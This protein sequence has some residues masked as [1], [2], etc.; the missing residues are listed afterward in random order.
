MKLI[1]AHI[2]FLA[3][4][5]SQERMS[6]HGKI[7]SSEDESAIAGASVLIVSTT[8]G[9]SSDAEGRFSLRKIPL[10]RRQLQISAV[11]YKTQVVE[12]GVGDVQELVIQLHPSLIQTQGVVV[13]A[14]K[15]AQSLEEIPVSMSVLDAKSFEVRNI[16]SL[17]DALRY[18]P[19]VNFQQSQ[20]NIR[21]SSG[22]SR[23]V[24]SR[25]A[26]LMDGVPLLAGDTKE[27]TFESIPVFQIDRVE[28]LKGAGSTL[29]GSGALGGVVN[30][31]TKDAE[32]TPT[33][34]WRVYSGMY[35]KPSFDQWKWTDAYR[36][37]NGQFLGF[38]SRFE[39]LGV[40]F[41][42]NRLSDDGYRDGDWLRRYNGFLKLKYDLSPY[43]SI[44]YSSNLFTQYRADF[45][46]WKNFQNALR[47]ADRQRD[48][49]VNSLR[50]N[51]SI[52]YKHFV[53]DEFYYDMKAV[54]FRGNWHRD[55]LNDTRLD[56][57]I[58]DAFVTDVQGNWTLDEKNILTFGIAGNYDR[59]RANIF[60]SHEGRGGA[61]YV[62]D[63]Y[64][65]SDDLS[66]TAGIRHDYQ[67]VFGSFTEQQTNPK[68]GMRYTIAEGSTV[69]LSV[70]RG[71]RSPSIGELFTSTSNT[72]SAAIVVPS[73]NLN[74][75]HSWTYEVS[76]THPLT[77]H[78]QIDL[79]LFHSD[80]YDLIEPHVFSDSLAKINFRNIT[81][82]QVRGFETSIRT[83][84]FDH[85]LLIDGHYNYNW[86]V[87]RNTNA[88]LRFRPRHIASV[89]S[90]FEYLFISTGVDYRFI[91]RIEQIDGQLIDLAPIVNGRQRVDIH[92]VD[93]R[94][95]ANLVEWGIPMRVALNVNN[96]LGYN[97]T[98]LIGNVAPPRQITVS[99]EGIVR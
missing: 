95:I 44:T 40:A 54:H 46:W 82:A 41:S 94:V 64:R 47:P 22:Y 85:A 15:R 32:E 27:I 36:F 63:E 88:F 83:A 4:L 90:S 86:A 6:V 28:V 61:I 81:Q 91:S 51:N 24:G 30:V 11:G 16:V 17:D 84:I 38:S 74:P 56:A 96:A 5:V 92:V 87:E 66:A 58:S 97:Y 2:V 1:V 53:T 8:L 31:L 76:G 35:S 21:V 37:T 14:N 10:E 9:T 65:L 48:I 69:R 20:I 19:G 77:E 78:I 59:V 13:T 80:F 73:L 68:F 25:V 7:V 42:L 67:E 98:E 89:N 45:L 49:T 71:F 55:G 39:N 72:G 23:G 34:F 18:V 12:L 29:Y 3:F 93:A 75:E 50:F 70:G 99:L 79:A 62:Q 43:Q 33:I 52:V 26:L 57:S 60:G